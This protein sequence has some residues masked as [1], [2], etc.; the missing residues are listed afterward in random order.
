[1]DIL[2]PVRRE[3]VLQG[4]QGN[5]RIPLTNPGATGFGHVALGLS[6]SGSSIEAVRGFVGP[7]LNACRARSEGIE[8]CGQQLSHCSRVLQ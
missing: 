6:L 3:E 5:L 8:V 7:L 2:L 1:M 4:V